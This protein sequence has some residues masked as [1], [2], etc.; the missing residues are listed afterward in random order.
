MAEKRAALE[1]YKLENVQETE[2]EL[3]RGSYAV[4]VKVN[5]KGLCCAGKKIHR[6]LCEQQGNLIS[7][8]EDECSLLSQLRHPHIVQFIGVYFDHETNLPVLVMEYLSTTLSQCLDRYGAQLP[9]SIRY[10]VLCDVS[11]GL[12]FLHDRARPIIH[13][14]LSANNVLLTADMTAKISDLGVAKIVNLPYSQVTKMTQ[15]PG[16]Q[17][18]MPPEALDP[19]PSYSTSMDVFSFG[20]L[21]IHVFSGKWPF[22][23]QATCVS[24]SNP[25]DLLP[26]SEADRRQEYLDVL[27]ANHPLMVLIHQCIHNNPINRPAA[28]KVLEQMNAADIH[29]PTSVTNKVEMLLQIKSDL[30]KKQ[31]LVGDLQQ[32]M[33]ATASL[34]KEIDYL[35][36]TSSVA[37]EHLQLE[38]AET[39][40]SLIQWEKEHRA[41]IRIKEEESRIQE[42]EIAELKTRIGLKEN[43]IASK[44]AIITS[45][46]DIIASKDDIIASSSAALKRRDSRSGSLDDRLQQHVSSNEPVSVFLIIFYL[47]QACSTL[48]RLKEMYPY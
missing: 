43:I 31:S 46:D 2:E 36:R 41:K 15:A 21:I 22:P 32:L 16:T 48:L 40:S 24:P 38:L 39:K 42:A 47:S 3:G 34:K 17:C 19:N 23:T 28:I 4:V 45:K 44:N 13:R 10:S 18:Y 26:V 11:L 9:D 30:E 8:F 27:G 20:I 25:N 5:Y 12:R 33:S 37:K 35:K 29:F 1:S 14:D 7:R 6:V